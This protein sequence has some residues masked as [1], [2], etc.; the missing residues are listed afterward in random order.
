L[1]ANFSGGTGVLTYGNNED[2][3]NPGV[4]T[5]YT[6]GSAGTHILTLTVTNTDGRKETITRTMEAFE[7]PLIT[8]FEADKP[9][10]KSGEQ[11]ILMCDFTGGT[12][13]LSAGQNNITLPSSTNKTHT[14]VTDT[15]YTLTVTNRAGYTYTRTIIV[16]V[17]NMQFNSLLSLRN[18]GN[19][20]YLF[21][22]PDS[23]SPSFTIGVT[24]NCDPTRLKFDSSNKNVA[25]INLIARTMNATVTVLKYGTTIISAIIDGVHEQFE[26]VVKREPN[27]TLHISKK[28]YGDKEFDVRSCIGNYNPSLAQYSA[29]SS[30]INVA[31]LLNWHITILKA[32]T[33]NITVTQ[34]ENE[35]FIAK[36]V[37]AI[38]EVDKKNVTITTTSISDVQVDTQFTFPL[39]SENKS[40]FQLKDVNNIKSINVDNNIVTGTPS[41]A[42]QC[43]FTVFQI[44]DDKHNKTELP[45]R[46]TAVTAPI[47][48]QTPIINW[49]IP[50]DV[51]YVTNA[52][53][54]I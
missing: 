11:V 29:K 45:I 1:T 23:S 24:T 17:C 32:G 15:H 3:V 6:P 34:L 10:I 41:K 16:R 18:I 25:T 2:I 52:I 39:R 54:N 12:A 26:L 9:H 7:Q 48:L 49:T 44:S 33:T 27:I 40:I 31:T 51:S 21:V 30:D 53:I 43:T 37:T 42:G 14:P 22:L 35:E 36:K 19:N 13:M 46:F 4:A 8:R 50:N 47:V 38:L 20:K 28:I 5:V